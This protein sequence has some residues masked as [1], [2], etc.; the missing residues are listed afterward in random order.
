MS[1]KDQEI[2]LG[3]GN[4]LEM[5]SSLTVTTYET[6]YLDDNGKRVAFEV[7]ISSNFDKLDEKLRESAFNMMSS[8]YLGIVSYGD[9]PFSNCQPAPKRRWYQFWK[10]KTSDI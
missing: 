8:R 6:L 3:N 5:K 7:N 4:N 10:S 2:N 1:K 9:N